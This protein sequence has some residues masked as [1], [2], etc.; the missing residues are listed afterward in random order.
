MDVSVVED[1]VDDMF[2][3]LKRIHII[4]FWL[5]EI[6]DE[7]EEITTNPATMENVVGPAELS[8]RLFSLSWFAGEMFQ[9]NTTLEF[10]QDSDV[11]FLSCEGAEL[12]DCMIL[13]RPWSWS[14]D[15]IRSQMKL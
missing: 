4:K 15:H 8:F 7:F 1:E 9:A 3:I 10:N 6:V 13:Q 5:A 2:L 14:M 12:Y 11:K